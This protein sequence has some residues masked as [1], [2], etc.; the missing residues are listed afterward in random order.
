MMHGEKNN[1]LSKNHWTHHEHTMDS[2]DLNKSDKY[3]SNKDKYLGLYFIWQYTVI[4]FIVGLIEAFILYYIL[5]TYTFIKVHWLVVI[6]WVLFFCIFQSSFWNTVHP[7]IHNISSEIRWNEGIPAWN[8]WKV[9]FSAIYINNNE[10]LYMWFKKNHTLHHLRK[11]ERK[12][13]YN[14]TLPGA[15]YFMGHY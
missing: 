7:D 2:M 14:V 12:G 4:V 3:N 9:L 15:D 10:T 11:K 5:Y 8:G 1:E 13:N 6:I